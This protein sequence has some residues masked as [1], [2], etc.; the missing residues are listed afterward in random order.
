[1]P[2]CAICNKP[3]NKGL[4]VDAECLE[5]I[6]AK[7]KRIYFVFKNTVDCMDYVHKPDCRPFKSERGSFCEKG[8]RAKR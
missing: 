7:Q 6:K 3:V 8:K 1:M 5:K 4:V 2:N